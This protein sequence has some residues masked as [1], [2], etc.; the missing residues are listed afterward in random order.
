MG[1]FFINLVV[2]TMTIVDAQ[3]L[4]KIIKSSDNLVQLTY[5]TILL[6]AVEEKFFY[7]DANDQPDTIKYH[8]YLQG[9]LRAIIPEEFKMK[10][11]DVK[12]MCLQILDTRQNKNWSFNNSKAFP[13]TL[14]KFFARQTK[15]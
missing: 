8:A 5:Q 2:L 13:R 6:P 7:Y 4:S 3:S 14:V 9:T 1:T 10:D 12:I 15:V 11:Q